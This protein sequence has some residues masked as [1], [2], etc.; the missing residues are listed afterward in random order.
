METGAPQILNK[1]L[2]LD[3]FVLGDGFFRFPTSLTEISDYSG[4]FV[5]LV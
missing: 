2:K 1:T 3:F 5:Y 4:S